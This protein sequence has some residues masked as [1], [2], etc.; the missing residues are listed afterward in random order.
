MKQS[1]AKKPN[2]KSVG[3]FNIGK[4]NENV[5]Q[6]I[7]APSIT[8]PTKKNKKGSKNTITQSSMP[9]FL[10][11]HSE[12]MLEFFGKKSGG[13]DIIFLSRIINL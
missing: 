8:S 5:L 3:I 2:P 6:S 7:K 10:D 1:M 13:L 9:N 12:Y 4:K 11:K